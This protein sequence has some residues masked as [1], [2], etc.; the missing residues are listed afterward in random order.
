MKRQKDE[1]ARW[2]K[3]HGKSHYG[4]Q[5]HIDIHKEHKLI[6]RYAVTDASVHDSQVFDELLDEESSGRSV[7]A[8]AAY[9]SEAREER[10]RNHGYESRIHRKGS[11]RHALNQQERA[12]NHRRSKIR[13]RVESVISVSGRATSWCA[14]RAAATVAQGGQTGVLAPENDHHM[15]KQGRRR[16]DHDDAG[17]RTD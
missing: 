14:P 10:L 9:R 16:V 15:A 13:A 4:Y 12:A 17:V 7:W 8:D 11:R 6:R 1:D 5:N 3:K 2:T